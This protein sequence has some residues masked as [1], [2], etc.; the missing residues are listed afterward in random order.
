MFGP[1]T[2]ETRHATSRRP[3]L[4][5]FVRRGALSPVRRGEW[6]EGVARGP[7]V[8]ETTWESNKKWRRRRPLPLA[9]HSP[10]SRNPSGL[11][12]PCGA[13]PSSRLRVE[14]SGWQVR[15][16]P[17]MLVVRRAPTAA[18]AAPH[19]SPTAGPFDYEPAVFC[20]CAKKAALWISWSDDNPGRRY[21]KCYH[22]RVSP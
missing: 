8:S 19:Q 16:A 3:F 21:F 5:G 11:P 4:G 22:G 14:Q 9:R 7:P 18:G 17:A 13:K 6:T 12:F 2:Y 10:S 1:R 20:H 15:R